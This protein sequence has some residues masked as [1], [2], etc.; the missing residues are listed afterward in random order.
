MDVQVHYPESRTTPML[1]NAATAYY[2]VPYM[3]SAM[4]PE[5]DMFFQNEIQPS[6]GFSSQTLPMG[7][8]IESLSNNPYQNLMYANTWPTP[9]NLPFN[10]TMVHNE[11]YPYS[12][13]TYPSMSY[14]ATPNVAYNGD[15]YQETITGPSN[16]LN[17]YNPYQFM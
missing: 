2:P 14:E 15:T 9:S 16:E 13:P 5:S 7:N 11:L 3:P 12:T 4:L 10:P 8:S 17:S 1:N 6:P